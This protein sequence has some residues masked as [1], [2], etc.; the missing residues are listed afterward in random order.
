MS[1][2]K[3]SKMHK[4]V[5]EQGLRKAIM[6]ESE[7]AKLPRAVRRKNG[8]ENNLWDQLERIY[9]VA[10]NGITI[11]DQVIVDEMVRTLED[12]ALLA[13]VKD[14]AA[15]TAMTRTLS[16]DLGNHIDR[17][18]TIHSKHAGQRG[19]ATFDRMSDV[20]SIFDEYTSAQEFYEGTISPSHKI[21]IGLLSGESDPSRTDPNVITDVVA[22]EVTEQPQTH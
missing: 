8:M 9:Q 20:M 7:G 19:S 1:L 13:R 22:R 6:A 4:A 18:N 3:I 17:L 21:I 15:L 12:P 16:T 11:S 14:P 2:P 5:Q 10:M